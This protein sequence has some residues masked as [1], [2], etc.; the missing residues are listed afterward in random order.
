MMNKAVLLLGGNMGNR[1]H[2]LET[3]CK[4]LQSEAGSIVKASSFVESEPWGFDDSRYFLNQVVVLET[5]FSP[6][7]L[8]LKLHEIENELGRKRT[9][10]Q[11]SSRTMDID[12]LY[13]NTD[14]VDSEA[15]TIPHK[16]LHNRLFTMLP[17]AEIEPDYVHPVFGKTNREL[18]AACEDKSKVKLLNGERVTL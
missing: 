2:N 3:A 8:L 15:L 17:L 10:K 14:V 6:E 11:Y 13:F 18:L 12:I 7:D 9:G 4:M 1:F 16:H 5:R